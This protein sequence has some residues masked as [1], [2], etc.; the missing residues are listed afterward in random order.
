MVEADTFDIP[1]LASASASPVEAE[2]STYSEAE[3]LALTVLV[4]ATSSF[5]TSKAKFVPRKA[6]VGATVLTL[7]KI[8]SGLCVPSSLSAVTTS[9]PF[10]SSD[11]ISLVKPPSCT[12]TIVVVLVVKSEPI[13]SAVVIPLVPGTG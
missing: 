9:D 2:L 5:T 1:V 11:T 13:T 4:E 6:A 8:T 3:A 7:L 12:P 10:V